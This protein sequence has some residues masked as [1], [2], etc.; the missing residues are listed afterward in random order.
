MVQIGTPEEILTEP[1]TGY[2]AEFVQDVDQGPVIEVRDVMDPPSSVTVNATLAEAL[3]A[4]GE[5]SGAFVVGADGVPAHLL[6]RE[7]GTRAARMGT[8]ELASALRSDFERCGPD[9]CLN[10]IY[11]AA[12]RGLPI[13]VC[14]ESGVLVGNVDPHRI[15][16]EMGRVE[17]LIDGFEREVFL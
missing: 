3:D 11:S 4:L 6:T 15:M 17:N 5:R 1:A 8:A 7:D 9:D 13:A 16:E 14:D 10:D 2:V 12:G